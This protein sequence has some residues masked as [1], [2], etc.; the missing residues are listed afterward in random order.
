MIFRQAPAHPNTGH[1]SAGLT[2]LSS[3]A[4]YPVRALPMSKPKASG[5]LFDLS[6]LFRL[7]RQGKESIWSLRGT[8]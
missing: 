2:V 5:D 6:G 7:F 8:K 4:S 3:S 1:V